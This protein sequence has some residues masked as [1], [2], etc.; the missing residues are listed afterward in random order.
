MKVILGTYNHISPGSSGK[1]FE[2]LYQT[3]WR[4]F[5]AVLYKFP[6]VN[7]VLYYSGTVLTWVEAK[8]PEFLML[9]DEMVSR[10][11]VE[12]LG[13]GFYSP[14]F[15]II[16]N[17]DKVGQI[18]LLTTYLRKTFGKR[19]SG[20]WL[21]E[22]AWDPSIPSIFRS[23]GLGYTFLPERIFSSNA[24]DD[25]TSCG[26][27]LTEDQ[28][29]TLS[30]FPVFDLNEME[31]GPE[32]FETA[33][34]KIV[35][36]RSECRLVTMMMDGNS[37]SS[38]W[39][40]SELESPDV[41]FER[42]FTWFQKNCLE[43]ETVTSQQAIKGLKQ[44]RLFYLA[45]TSSEK[46]AKAGI[47]YNVAG[48]QTRQ[49]DSSILAK[50]MIVDNSASAK[51][52]TKMNYIDTLIAM[53]RGDKARKKNASEDLWE[54]QS[55]DSYWEGGGGGIRRPEI[56]IAAFS[57]L[58]DAEKTIRLHANSGSGFVFD[59]IDCD[60]E[61]ELVYQAPDYNSYL[62]MKGGCIFELDSFKTKHNYLCAYEP[63]SK[64][65]YNCFVDS[66][67][68][69]GKREPGEPLAR[70]ASQLYS[71]EEYDKDLHR[72]V[73]SKKVS[74]K[75]DG[76]PQSVGIRKTFLFQ[77]RCISVD[78]EVVNNTST[79][80]Q[81][82]FCSELNILPKA[83]PDSLQ[84]S[85]LRG[86]DKETIPK[87]EKTT[88]KTTAS[89]SELDAFLMETSC[90]KEY[91]EIRSDKK[92]DLNVRHMFDSFN[93]GIPN[94][95]SPFILQNDY[96]IESLYQ[97]SRFICG[98]DLDFAPDSSRAFSLSLHLLS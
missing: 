95:Q 35:A 43:Y 28:R 9:L 6:A 2:Q 14:I 63:E 4:P 8:H 36:I 88:A 59:D 85:L 41:M 1:V 58:I 22:Y 23:S 18:E 30:V 24:L 15:P 17:A 71:I 60:G 25:S 94:G 49:G 33:L 52:F 10:K 69:Y 82:R 12:L 93:Q 97:G 86:H 11:Q 20:G 78:Y 50:Q 26:V 37:A 48:I 73:L 16:P 62:H 55:G 65:S 64:E 98:W 75:I 5:L 29:K 45:A 89:F 13:G 92:F 81:F 40:S 87:T 7:S 80:C 90:E 83:D 19:P 57:A 66:L 53:L 42:T 61:K 38:V 31:G 68:T 67:E 56:R 91:I 47:G 27:M 70:M 79:P 39:K 77:K 72:I 34:A 46:L 32:P 3:C 44:G 76:V 51:L 84:I 54:A 74:L 96:Y 21:Y